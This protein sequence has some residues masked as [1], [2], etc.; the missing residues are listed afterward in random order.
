MRSAVITGALLL[1]FAEAFFAGI[2]ALVKHLSQTLS[3]S[4][5]VFFRNFFALILVLP[6]AIKNGISELRTQHLKF[7]LLRAALGIIAMYCFFYVLAHIPLAE[8]MM[9]ILLSPFFVPLIAWIWLQEKVSHQTLLAILLAFAGAL[10][11]LS[12]SQGGVN[13]YMLIALSGAI[14][15][16]FT[17]VTIRHLTH[18]EP[19]GRIVFYFAFFATLVSAVPMLLN[20]QPISYYNLALLLAIGALAAGGQVLMTQAF[21]LVSPGRIGLLTNVQVIFAAALGYWFWDEP[22]HQ[23]L[24]MGGVLIFWAASITTRQRWLI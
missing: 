13:V 20:W 15:V 7:H 16:A 21:K 14:L 19:T 8:A 18:S 6:W 3:Q 24:I 17:K 9:V 2:G 10:L 12:P 23:G 4:Q 22:I 5:L 11:A 1:V